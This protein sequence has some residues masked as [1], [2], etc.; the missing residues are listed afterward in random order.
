MAV[1]ICARY[2]TSKST[3]KGLQKQ[4][5]KMEVQWVEWTPGVECTCPVK[6]SRP[7]GPAPYLGQCGPGSQAERPTH[8]SVRAQVPGSEPPSPSF[9]K[10]FRTFTRFLRSRLSLAPP[11]TCQLT[12]PALASL[13]PSHLW[14]L[15][16]PSPELQEETPHLF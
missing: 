11:P 8:C 14:E 2:V 6:Q 12:T 9:W 1:R 15:K 4:Q 5:T 10:L 13:P 7:G 16:P 3:Q